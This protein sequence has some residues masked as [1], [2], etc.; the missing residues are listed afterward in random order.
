[1]TG[2]DGVR[3]NEDRP[4]VRYFVPTAALGSYPHAMAFWADG[5]GGVALRL[6]DGAAAVARA[7]ASDGEHFSFEKVDHVT[8]TT[9]RGR[10]IGCISEEAHHRSSLVSFALTPDALR[11]AHAATV[12]G[13]HTQVESDEDDEAAAVQAALLAE[14][15]AVANAAAARHVELNARREAGRAAQLAKAAAKRARRGLPCD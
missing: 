1:M 13:S 10:F 14:R 4:K 15:E 12:G 9:V 8:R 7:A 6:L 3:F 11:E 5:K 2:A